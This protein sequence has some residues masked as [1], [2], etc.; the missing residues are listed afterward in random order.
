MTLQFLSADFTGRVNGETT[1][2][3]S[4]QNTSGVNGETTLKKH[5]SLQFRVPQLTLNSTSP[6]FTGGV[7]G[8]TNV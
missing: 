2:I 1:D 8:E 7:N 4:F 3:M 6:D 5:Q